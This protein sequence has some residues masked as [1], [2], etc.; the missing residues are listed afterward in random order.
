MTRPRASRPASFRSAGLFAVAPLAAAAQTAV[1]LVS[2]TAGAAARRRPKELLALAA[3]ALGLALPG[4][5]HAQNSAPDGE[6]HIYC[7]G[8]ERRHA[9]PPVRAGGGPEGGRERAARDR[10]R[11]DARD[12]GGGFAEEVRLPVVP[13][14]GRRA[15]A[16]ANGYGQRPIPLQGDETRIWAAS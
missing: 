10:R 5:A 14:E 11:R 2:N 3:L 8:P 16:A 12:S 9:D 13:R 4:L 1:T 6:V 15:N 7:Q